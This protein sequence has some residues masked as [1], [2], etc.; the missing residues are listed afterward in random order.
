[1]SKTNTGITDCCT[2]GHLSACFYVSYGIVT[3]LS[4]CVPQKGMTALMKA[5]VQ[6]HT[7][8]IR[9]LLCGEAQLDLQDKV[10]HN[11]NY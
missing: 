10:G 1:M 11:I 3:V 8:I 7:D 4:H 2:T 5:S 6:G 9:E